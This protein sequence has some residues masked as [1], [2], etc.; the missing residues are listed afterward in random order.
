MSAQTNFVHLHQR[1]E[2]LDARRTKTTAQFKTRGHGCFFYLF[3]EKQLHLVYL[4]EVETLWYLT[5]VY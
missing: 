2:L 3:V 5:H 1:I 4:G